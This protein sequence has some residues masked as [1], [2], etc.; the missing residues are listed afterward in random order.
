MQVVLA[1]K[2][3]TIQNQNGNLLKLDVYYK[4]LN[5]ELISEYY[6]YP[7]SI[8]EIHTTLHVNLQ[9]NN[10]NNN[11]DDDEGSCHSYVVVVVSY[12]GMNLHQ[13]SEVF[14]GFG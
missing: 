11:D 13:I 8:Y 1:G 3:H 9:N 4:L 5:Y 7:V 2:H 6:V 12:R 10:S 14:L